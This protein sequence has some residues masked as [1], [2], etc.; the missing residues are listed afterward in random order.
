M[1]D[2]SNFS[3][4]ETNDAH[5]V[6]NLDE[7]P[8]IV[9]L[10][11]QLQTPSEPLEFLSRSWSLSANEVSKAIAQKQK[12]CT[13]DKNSNVI[14]ETVITQQITDKVMIP[15]SGRRHG[16]IGRWFH[17]KDAGNM[18]MKKKDKA[19]IENAQ[20]HAALTVAGLAA[21]LAAV[22]AAG[23]SEG[24]GSRMGSALASATELLACHCIELAESAG[25]D[26]D[27]VASTIRSAVDIH[28]A[29][30][31]I[32]LT[33]AA[34]TAL[35]GEAA[36]KARFPKEAKRNAAITPCD[37]SM[38]E[39]PTAV[40]FHDELMEQ[41][42][43][44]VG[45][46]LHQTEK[47]VQWKHVSVYID[48]KS[49]V[50][51]RLKSKN[52]GAFSKKNK[53]VVYEVCDQTEMQSFKKGTENAEVYFGIKTARG[54]LE[55]KCKNKDHRQTWIDGIQNL[56]MITCGIEQ[57]ERSQKLLTTTKSF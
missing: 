34:A 32:T 22:A 19:R 5:W 9:P 49:Q 26:H 2:R 56:L 4:W 29:S 46:L 50:I 35:R 11:P 17:H 52:V 33:A 15:V 12:E 18:S 25:A 39:A 13:F 20:A 40:G 45:D 57:V 55:F 16:V 38:I 37:K 7:D 21:G 31:L 51:M 14:P 30:D 43:P 53:C 24:S 27:R 28:S 3:G 41:D 42:P 8:S 54:I 10:L 23:N 48:K 6:Q 47:G 44:C 1:N 36:L